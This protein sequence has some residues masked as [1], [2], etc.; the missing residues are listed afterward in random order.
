[1]HQHE[2]AEED[3]SPV[4][5]GSRVLVYV[6]SCS[7]LL[8][9]MMA[10]FDASSVLTLAIFGDDADPVMGPLF[11]IVWS[12]SSV[13][14]SLGFLHVFHRLLVYPLSVDMSEGK[15]AIV[16]RDIRCY[17]VL[18]TLLGVC[19][20]WVLMEILLGMDG[21]IKYSA[22]MLVVV[23]MLSLVY[24][25]II[26]WDIKCRFSFGM[27]LGFLSASIFMEILSFKR[28][29]HIKYYSAAMLVGVMMLSLIFKTII[30][31]DIE[32]RFGLGMLLGACS[33]WVV[34]E[35]SPGRDEQIIYSA[36][37]LACVIMLSL[38][39]QFCSN[40]FAPISSSARKPGI[41][42]RLGGNAVLTQCSEV[43]GDAFLIV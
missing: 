33:A 22:G 31:L 36:G 12:C 5:V 25:T 2:K 15:R 30:I 26:I 11:S 20:A 8:G 18:G 9:L 41:M 3:L 16:I 7:F 32:C 24:K 38:I 23:M 1:M 35:I 40:K 43:N 27:M 21:Y 4:V 28:E 19:S 6:Q 13:I 10:F 14:I 34:M 42:T 39:S 17:F 29:E 37:L